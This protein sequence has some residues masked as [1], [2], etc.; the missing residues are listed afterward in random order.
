MDVAARSKN[1]EGPLRCPLCH[2]DVEAGAAV[3]CAGCQAAHHAECAKGGRCASCAG[4]FAGPADE[5]PRWLRV[6]NRV[7]VIVG[8]LVAVGCLLALVLPRGVINEVFL[9][10]ALIGSCCAGVAAA[11]AVAGLAHAA[12]WASR[13]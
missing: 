11:G 10:G 2:D 9:G 7:A 12:W 3:L 5:R 8:V 13:A 1:A 4:S 6:A